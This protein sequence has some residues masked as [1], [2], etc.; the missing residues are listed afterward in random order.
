MNFIE[1]FI[2]KVINNKTVLI[3]KEFNMNFIFFKNKLE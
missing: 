3:D 2:K 1:P